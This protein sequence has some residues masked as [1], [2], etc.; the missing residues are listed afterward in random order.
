M[1]ILSYIGILIAVIGAIGF[2]IAAFRESILWGLGCLL[3]SPVS[4]AFL[5][6]HWSE[7][8]NPF[9]LQLAGIGLVLLAASMGSEVHFLW[10]S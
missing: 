3:I 7:A 6:M 10:F 9:S 4:I 2:L 5:F 8:K 1:E